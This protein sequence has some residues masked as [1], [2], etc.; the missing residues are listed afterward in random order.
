[1]WLV[2]SVHEGDDGAQEIELLNCNPKKKKKKKKKNE[3]KGRK[4]Y[5]IARFGPSSTRF[6]SPL[7][8]QN[9]SYHLTQCSSTKRT[10]LELCFL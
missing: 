1:M 3:R 9:A 7:L 10:K 5:D 6:C 2:G 8:A 4:R